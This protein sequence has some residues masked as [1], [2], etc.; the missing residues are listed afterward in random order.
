[1][2]FGTLTRAFVNDNYARGRA[3]CIFSKTPYYE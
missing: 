1:L 3:A 2:G